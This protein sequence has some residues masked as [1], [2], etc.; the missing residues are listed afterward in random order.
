MGGFNSWPEQVENKIGWGGEA[1]RKLYYNHEAA[2]QGNEAF[3]QNF[4]ER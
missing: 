3:H 2:L 1:I 4:A